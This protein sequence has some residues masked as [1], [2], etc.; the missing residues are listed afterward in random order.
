MEDETVID[1]RYLGKPD[2]ALLLGVTTRSIDN[3]TKDGRLP[4]PERLPNG[5]PAWRESVIRGAVKSAA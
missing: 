5:R 4:K 2:V 3:W 1:D